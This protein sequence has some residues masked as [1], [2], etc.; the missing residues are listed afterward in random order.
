[1]LDTN[2]CAAMGDL[3]S[4]NLEHLIEALA[5]RIAEKLV[6]GIA[7][8]GHLLATA[9]QFRDSLNAFALLK[10][11]GHRLLQRLLQHLVGQDGRIGSNLGIGAHL[12]HVILLC[13]DTLR[14][15]EDG[16]HHDSLR[17]RAAL[18]DM[19]HEVLLMFINYTIYGI[20]SPKSK[21]KESPTSTIQ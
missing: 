16:F 13:D 7:E 12:N 19:L 3:L 2:A 18:L 20:K 17:L 14:H 9:G 15:R 5:L 4:R 6:R 21:K 8:Q 10:I 11:L 1:M